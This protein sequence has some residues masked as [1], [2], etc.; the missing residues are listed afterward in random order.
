MEP[1][2]QI[3][4]IIYLLFAL[5][6]FCALIYEVLWTKYLSL[7]FGTTMIA[8]SVVAATF[9][10][11][12]ALGSFLLGRFADHETN[13]LQVYAYLELGIGMTA[14]IFPPSLR[15]VERLYVWIHHAS[16]ESIDLSGP[17]H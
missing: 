9:M 12:L 10:G 11:G 3:K 1:T 13:L 15:L 2:A 4:R 7:T 8:V 6:G 14:L 16:P 17:L 5:S